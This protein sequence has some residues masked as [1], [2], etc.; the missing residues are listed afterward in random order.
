M[1]NILFGVGLLLMILLYGLTLLLSSSTVKD[2]GMI[3]RLFKA[4]YLT[5]DVGEKK[6]SKFRK[7]FAKIILLICFTIRKG[8]KT[9]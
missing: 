9:N 4:G 3:I 7:F 2:D 8:R 6:N 1:V 5:Y